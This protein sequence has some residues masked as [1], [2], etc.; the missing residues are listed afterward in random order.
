M[1]RNLALTFLTAAL[2]LVGV[3]A[4]ADTC[5]NGTGYLNIAGS[6]AA[7]EIISGGVGAL[8]ADAGTTIVYWGGGS[9]SGL[10][11]LYSGTVGTG[12][13]K[14]YA[15]DGTVTSC[16]LPTA[17]GVV[18]DMVASD[19][20]PVTCQNAG[21]FVLT[22]DGIPPGF[23][24]IHGPWQAM[25]F[26]QPISA[27]GPSGI[28][29]EQAYWVL[30]FGPN[31]G[32]VSPWNN[33]NQNNSVAM[34]PPY[35]TF[36]RNNGSGTQDM[37]TA[38]VYQGYEQYAANWQG[39]N[40]GSSGN[41][42]SGVGGSPSTGANSVIGIVALD[43]YG[44]NRATATP[45]LKDLPFRGYG[46]STAWYPDSSQTANDRQNVRNGLY[47][48]T[49]PLH[50]I[51]PCTGTPCTNITI[52]EAAAF[53]N[54]LN[55]TTQLT[56]T[57]IVAVAAQQ[58]VTPDCA[59][60]VQRAQDGPPLT[61]YVPSHLCGCA[62]EHDVVATSSIVPYAC[63][64]CTCPTGTACSATCSAAQPICNYGYCEAQ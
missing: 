42:V 45:T 38:F 37:I 58:F 33:A 11:S 35:Y 3:R 22:T 2:A 5:P 56:G 1:R 61:S 12:S 4:N 46:Q 43:A 25:L 28:A 59:M 52:P 8:L 39:Y 18:A 19:V 54:V 29:A 14:I 32:D 57:D 41:V 34:M 48:M 20:Y 49:G 9:C 17:P 64:A 47:Q 26:V 23:S 6:T 24:E 63:V 13:A 21:A 16:T 10:D 62:F 15:A 44:Q 60:Q 50:F 36:I 53:L 30:G 27:T 40:A 51:T 55:G 7:G 31:G